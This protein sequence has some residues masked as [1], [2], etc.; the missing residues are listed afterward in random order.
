[1]GGNKV[2]YTYTYPYR[3]VGCKGTKWTILISLSFLV[4][5][6]FSLLGQGRKE[7]EWK[8]INKSDSLGLRR[9]WTVFL[10]ALESKQNEIIREN[11]LHEISCDLC[12]NPDAAYDPTK[13]FVPIDTFLNQTNRSFLNSPLYKAI[14]TRDVIFSIRTIPDY[15]PENVPKTDSQDFRLYE[16]WVITYLPDEW[17]KGHEGQS[18]AFQFLKIKDKFKFYG[19]TS[20][21]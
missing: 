16:I 20:V 4:L 17:A 10:D 12:R 5:L 7:M 2:A 11:S 19:L 15:H 18:H 1:V 8:R 14:K 9:T 6:P 13:D 21:P 3:N